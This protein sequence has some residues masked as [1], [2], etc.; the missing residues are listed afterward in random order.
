MNIWVPRALQR[1]LHW[2][3]ITASFSSEVS[4]CPALGTLGFLNVDGHP[5]TSCLLVLM[6]FLAPV[7]GAVTPPAAD[8]YT[9]G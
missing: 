4:F 5:R 1:F 9:V 6:P 7:T 3:L 2:P 8:Y